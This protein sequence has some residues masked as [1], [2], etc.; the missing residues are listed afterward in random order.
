MIYRF[1]QFFAG[2][3]TGQSYQADIRRPGQGQEIRRTESL[4]ADASRPFS[5]GSATNESPLPVKLT[6]NMIMGSA[7]QLADL[8][9]CL[10]V[11]TASSLVELH[12]EVLTNCAMLLP[13]VRLVRHNR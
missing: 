12:K 13:K 11:I 10:V 6:L 7:R 3:I 1:I 8:D 2:M 5:P 9:Q 4:P